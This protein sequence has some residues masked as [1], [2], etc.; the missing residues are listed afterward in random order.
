MTQ[1]HERG[2]PFAIV[3]DMQHFRLLELPLE[4]VDLLDSPNPPR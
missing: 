4:I 1:Q 2:V 3:H